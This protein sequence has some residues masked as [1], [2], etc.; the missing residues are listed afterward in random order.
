MATTRRE[1]NEAM[2]EGGRGELV[3]GDAQGSEWSN[4]QGAIS[5]RSSKLLQRCDELVAATQQQR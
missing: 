3:A 1:Q 2:A 4:A 5:E